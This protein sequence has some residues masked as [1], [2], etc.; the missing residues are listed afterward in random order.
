MNTAIYSHLL[1]NDNLLSKHNKLPNYLILMNSVQCGKIK[2]MH[3][4]AKQNISLLILFFSGESPRIESAPNQLVSCWGHKACVKS[5]SGVI[6]F[7]SLLRLFFSPDPPK[8][9]NS[10]I[11]EIYL[12]CDRILTYHL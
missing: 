11:F 12:H 1:S 7:F 10:L 5:L 6:S 2:L 8:S 4:Q 9:I 3:F